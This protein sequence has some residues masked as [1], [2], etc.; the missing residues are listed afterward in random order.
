MTSHMASN[1]ANEA[2]Y[3]FPK[4]FPDHAEHIY[5]KSLP[6]S[7]NAKQQYVIKLAKTA[8]WRHALKIMHGTRKIKFLKCFSDQVKQL[9]S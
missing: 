9:Q 4:W 5:L 8:K 2:L 1:V 6:K 7:L 3:E